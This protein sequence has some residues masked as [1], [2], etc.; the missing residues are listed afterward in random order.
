MGNQEWLAE[1]L[2]Y[3]FEYNGEPLPVNGSGTPSTPAAWYYSRNEESYGIDGTYK[4]G[5]LYNGYAVDYLEANK[6]TLL[7]SGWHVPS[8]S[9]WETMQEHIGGSSAG[10]TKLKA[11]PGSLDGS[12]PSESW[13]GTDD[14]KFTA[15]PS[16]D[17]W[18]GNFHDIG[19]AAQFWTT[20]VKPDSYVCGYELLE[21]SPAVTETGS[22]KTAASSIRLVK[23]LS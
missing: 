11:I 21:N 18:K 7:P 2:D 16:G 8:T 17:M 12:W 23:T 22:R 4:C 13:G 9:E 1:N 19:V 14:Y 6:A 10:G 5:L 20:T 3:K 15:Y